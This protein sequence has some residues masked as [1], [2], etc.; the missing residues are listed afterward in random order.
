MEKI[1]VT[2]ATGFIGGHLVSKLKE[3]GFRVNILVRNKSGISKKGVFYGD[4]VKNRGLESFLKGARVIVN[5]VGGYHPPFSNQL[6]TNPLALNNLCEAAVKAGVKK[7]IHISSS[8]VYG[9][10]SKNGLFTE[11]DKANPDT[12]YGLSKYFSEE[13]ASYYHKNYGLNFII[14]RPSNVY[15]PGNEDGVIYRFAKS[16]KEKGFIEI[17]GDG[18]NMRDYFFV[19]DMVD[20]IV[21]AIAFNCQ[22]EVFNVGLGKAYSLLDVVSLFEKVLGQRVKIRY[23]KEL[24]KT[25]YLIASNVNKAKKLLK[26]QPKYSLEKGLRITLSQIS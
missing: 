19:D 11:K 9:S 17:F 18:K 12:L 14:L 20:V 6:E 10:R 24:A 21:K 16:I 3:D 5:L 8:A 15:G 25:S 4:L 2:G 7:I 26:W 1:A 23:K 13:V 22:F